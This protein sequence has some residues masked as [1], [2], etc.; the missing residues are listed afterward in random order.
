MG[1]WGHGIRQ[2]DFVLDIIGDFEDLLKAGKSVREASDATGRAPR[3]R[4]FQRAFSTLAFMRFGC[5]FSPF[6]IGHRS[7]PVICVGAGGAFIQRARGAR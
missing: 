7:S 1:A 4:C 5:S 2:D 6:R 3:V